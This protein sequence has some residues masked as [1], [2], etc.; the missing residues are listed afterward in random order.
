MVSFEWK[1]KKYWK[2]K[3]WDR[4]EKSSFLLHSLIQVKFVNFNPL[5]RVSEGLTIS[6]KTAKKITVRRK[7]DKSLALVAKKLSVKNIFLVTT[8]ESY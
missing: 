7:I 5:M 8:M 1:Q 2:K 3:Q 4:D 6:R